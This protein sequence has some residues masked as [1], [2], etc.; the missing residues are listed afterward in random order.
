MPDFSI[1]FPPIMSFRSGA[2]ELFERLKAILF[3]A[4]GGLWSGE[5]HQGS[6]KLPRSVAPA[7]ARLLRSGG[8]CALR[9]VFLTFKCSSSIL[10]LTAGVVQ[11]RK[12]GNAVHSLV[13]FCYS[14]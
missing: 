12:L 10:S 11:A 7:L 6:Y 2:V 4:R 1:H 14:F 3:C 5:E 8:V 9:V 13:Q